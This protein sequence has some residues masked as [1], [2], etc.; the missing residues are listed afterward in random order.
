MLLENA[1]PLRKAEKEREHGR[2]NFA[3]V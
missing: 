1:F 2:E 3:A